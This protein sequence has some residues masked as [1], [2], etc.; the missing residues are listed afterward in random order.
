MN[1][2]TPTCHAPTIAIVFGARCIV[3]DAPGCV[4][5]NRVWV[6]QDY[7]RRLVC[8]LG[9]EIVL[10]VKDQGDRMIS[11]EFIDALICFARGIMWV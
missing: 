1:Q 10:A 5:A 2:A 8:I 9:K 6:T 7:V 4:N 11:I 3:Y